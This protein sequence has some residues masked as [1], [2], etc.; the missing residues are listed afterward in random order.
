MTKSLKMNFSLVNFVCLR[1]Q[2]MSPTNLYTF[3]YQN[4]LLSIRTNKLIC[5]AWLYSDFT[6][7]FRFVKIVFTNRVT[8]VLRLC[9]IHFSSNYLVHTIPTYA[10]QLHFLFVYL[11]ILQFIESTH[12]KTDKPMIS[13]LYGTFFLD[14]QTLKSHQ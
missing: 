5:L 13:Q 10:F 12:H 3:L 1:Y 9:T 2:M 7:F 8:Q 6:P 11:D 4:N 14:Y